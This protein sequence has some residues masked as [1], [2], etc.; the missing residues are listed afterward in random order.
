MYL[1]NQDPVGHSIS[2][3]KKGRFSDMRIVGVIGDVKQ[4]KVTDAQA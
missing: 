4:T 1:P 3:G 2:M